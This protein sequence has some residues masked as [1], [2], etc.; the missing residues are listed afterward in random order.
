MQSVS[1]TRLDHENPD[2]EQ[3]WTFVYINIWAMHLED[4][5]ALC[6][7]RPSGLKEEFL[8]GGLPQK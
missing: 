4:V 2:Y 3:A 1:R 7:V 5:R 8:G 6:R